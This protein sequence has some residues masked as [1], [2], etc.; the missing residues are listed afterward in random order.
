MGKEERREGEYVP[1]GEGI[2]PGG[3]Q[4][5]PSEDPRKDSGLYELDEN[6]ELLLDDK[7]EPILKSDKPK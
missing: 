4:P 3:Q 6:G 5:Q 7:G 1:P 2:S